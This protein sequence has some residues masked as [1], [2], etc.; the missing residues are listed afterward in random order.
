MQMQKGGATRRPAQ[1]TRCRLG[2]KGAE[3]PED[4]T[5]CRALRAAASLRWKIYFIGDLGMIR[6]P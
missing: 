5:S 2:A 6:Q 4:S 3:A 1:I